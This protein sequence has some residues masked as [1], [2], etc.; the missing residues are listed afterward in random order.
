MGNTC[1]S[2]R[3]PKA[4]VEVVGNSAPPP[5]E[6]GRR[7][8]VSL[9]QLCKENPPELSA[10]PALR[11]QVGDGPLSPTQ[12]RT[13]RN[14]LSPSPI[15]GTDRVQVPAQAHLRDS[16]Q[17]TTAVPEDED[18]RITASTTPLWRWT[19]SQC[20]TWI[21]A[22][23]VE[24]AGKTIEEA[25]VLAAAFKGWGPNLYMKEWRQ[26]N[27]WLGQDGQA[28]FALLMEVHGQE[29]AVPVTVEIAHYALEDRKRAQ[30]EKLSK[31]ESTEAA[32]GRET[33]R[34]R[35]SSS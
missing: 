16:T 12:F 1:S 32:K 28:I 7:S 26:W 11:N 29:G 33:Q 35:E 14:T 8:I 34:R 5:Y 19:N 6:P 17:S 23:L 24:Y 13:T 15:H 27:S 22:V 25:K 18:Q 2:I 3:R 4:R 30:R 31:T 20:Q 21:A 9:D 10:H